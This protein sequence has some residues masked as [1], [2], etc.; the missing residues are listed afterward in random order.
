MPDGAVLYAYPQPYQSNQDALLHTEA[1]S[2]VLPQAGTYTFL[3][4][5]RTSIYLDPHVA[6]DSYDYNFEIGRCPPT[7]RPSRS[8]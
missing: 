5:A 8:H 6:V 4:T 7:R 1:G 2:L 3:V